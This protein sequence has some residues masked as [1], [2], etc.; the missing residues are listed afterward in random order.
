MAQAQGK[1]KGKG[2]AQATDAVPYGGVQ[3]LLPYLADAPGTGTGRGWDADAG[4][5]QANV[6]DA[7]QA[8]AASDADAVATMLANLANGS[9][10]GNAATAPVAASALAVVALRDALAAAGQPNAWQVL[11]GM[12]GA[13]SA[14]TAR[15]LY[16]RAHGQPGAH[17][18][19]GTVTVRV[20]QRQQGAATSKQQGS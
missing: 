11:A 2:K 14:G 1:G 13:G 8:L 5:V 7:V 15:T 19:S 4:A 3:A 10:A 20:A 18:H 6:Q 17:K 12:V 16:N 9:A